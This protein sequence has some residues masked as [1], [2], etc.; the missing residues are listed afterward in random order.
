MEIQLES[1]PQW[2][3]SNPGEAGIS[4]ETE[5]FFLVARSLATSFRIGES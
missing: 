5:E 2:R 1:L 4:E 3:G